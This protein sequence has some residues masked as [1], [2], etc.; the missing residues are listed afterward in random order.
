[1][2]Y[3]F[4]VFGGDMRQIYIGD[5]LQEAGYSV[6]RYGM[7]REEGKVEDDTASSF[8]SLLEHSQVLLGPIPLTK[9]Q[10]QVSHGGNAKELN[11]E[12]LE[13][14]LE[15]GK[16]LIAGCIPARLQRKGFWLY[17]YMKDEALTVFNS[18]A[19]AEGAIARAIGE[20]E[21]NLCRS[22]CLVVGYGVCAKTLASCLSGLKANMCICARREES[23]AEANTL[24]FDAIS[25]E[26]LDRCLKE[27]DYIF[28]TVPAQVLGKEELKQVKREAVIIDLAS[29]PGGVDYEWA[30]GLG[31]HARLCPGLPGIYA[32]RASAKA[33]AEV[34]KKVYNQQKQLMED[35]PELHAA[36]I[37]ECD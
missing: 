36:N 31:L 15:K 9:D 8:F 6:L 10:K 22:R 11:M 32:P 13:K 16:L 30:E 27:F 26:E 3:D 21:G 28:N 18:I 37:R 2:I 24:G 19:T 1:M 17:D 4:G 12:D 14:E 33:M 25:F 35:D 5:E 34:V 23:R 29:A 20:G 7:C